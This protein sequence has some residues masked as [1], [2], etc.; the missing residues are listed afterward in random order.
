MMMTCHVN[1][2]VENNVDNDL[3]KDVDK[4]MNSDE[5]YNDD[6]HSR[7]WGWTRVLYPV[8]LLRLKDIDNNEE[9]GVDS[10]DGSNEE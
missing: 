9:S 1:K 4:D 10:N 2:D 6:G 8:V 5:E 3:D 7:Y